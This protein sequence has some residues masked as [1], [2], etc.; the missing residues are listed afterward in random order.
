MF[1]SSHSGARTVKII[2][3]QVGV[4]HV[5]KIKGIAIAHLLQSTSCH[6]VHLSET[7]RG[8]THEMD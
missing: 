7:G 8:I 3:D 4:A 2:P 5:G 6:R 1:C